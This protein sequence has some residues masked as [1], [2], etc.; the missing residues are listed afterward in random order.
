M[1]GLLRPRITTC[2]AV[3]G[4]C[5]I[6]A[7]AAVIGIGDPA[8]DELQGGDGGPQADASMPNDAPPPKESGA[9]SAP[10][11][12]A[13][14][15]GKQVS[16][17]TTNCSVATNSCCVYHQPQTASFVFECTPT[18][19]APS[20]SAREVTAL[21]CAAPA[22]CGGKQCC[23]AF[24]SFDMQAGTS[25][26]VTTC[27]TTCGAN[28]YPLCDPSGPNTCGT[29]S[30]CQQAQESLTGNYGYCRKNTT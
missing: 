20:S 6:T 10:V 3:V 22:D 11:D 19:R 9:D 5:A 8:L 23:Y 27:K 12:A 4:S 14:D 2:L 26:A 30:H 28:E 7:C 13:P 17:G 29:S 18:C 15:A 16:C 25:S 24:T 1:N 21:S